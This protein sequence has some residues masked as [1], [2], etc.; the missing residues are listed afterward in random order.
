MNALLTLAI[1][2]TPCVLVF[3]IYYYLIEKP[4]LDLRDPSNP[5]Q[6]SKK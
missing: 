4:I 5:L 1:L 3:S 6:P 2:W